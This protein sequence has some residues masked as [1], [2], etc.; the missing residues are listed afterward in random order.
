[1]GMKRT[2]AVTL[3]TEWSHRLANICLAHVLHAG[4]CL[5]STA[6][7]E[8]KQLV[9]RALMHHMGAAQ[10]LKMAELADAYLAATAGLVPH[11][12][13]AVPCRTNLGSHSP[14]KAL[15]QHGAGENAL[16]LS[17]SLSLLL[18]LSP[19]LSLSLSLS[20]SKAHWALTSKTHSVLKTKQEHNT[21]F[22]NK[23]HTLH[24]NAPQ[25]CSSKVT[26]RMC[27]C[28]HLHIRAAIFKP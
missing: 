14:S 17:L 28:M 19:S 26:V 6:A 24:D 27:F 23:E 21:H 18:S 3:C 12:L 11:L 25:F 8:S 22:K 1:M 5:S 15:A 13:A 20:L 9:E 7:V 16:S 4:V 2:A 10:P